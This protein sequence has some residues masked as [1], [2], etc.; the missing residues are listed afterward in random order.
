MKFAKRWRHVGNRWIPETL[1]ELTERVKKNTESPQD[2]KVTM[3][4][5][6]EIIYYLL[7]EAY[8]SELSKPIIDMGAGPDTYCD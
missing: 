4:A 2:V 5:T 7:D 8:K 1:D 6:I 3:N